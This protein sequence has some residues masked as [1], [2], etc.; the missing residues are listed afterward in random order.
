MIIVEPFD[1]AWH[2]DQRQEFDNLN[3]AI[4][5]GKSRSRFLDTVYIAC[6][7]N[8]NYARFLNGEAFINQG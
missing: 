4:K 3:E 8:K 1:G 6:D 5:F 2:D 7:E